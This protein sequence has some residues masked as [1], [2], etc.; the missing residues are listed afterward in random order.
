MDRLVF[1]LNQ[2]SRGIPGGVYRRGGTDGGFWMG[3]SDRD[4]AA[5]D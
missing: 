2:E 4:G 5:I 3:K 1:F